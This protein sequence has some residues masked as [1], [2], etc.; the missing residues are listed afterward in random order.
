MTNRF[1]SPLII[2]VEDGVFCQL[3]TSPHDQ[4]KRN[5]HFLYHLAQRG[6]QVAGDFCQKDSVYALRKQQF[7]LSFFFLQESEGRPEVILLLTIS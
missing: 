5:I 7:K 6:P 2:V 1:V 4:N 3:W